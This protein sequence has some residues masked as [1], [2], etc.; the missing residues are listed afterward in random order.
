VNPCEPNRLLH[1]TQIDCRCQTSIV[2]EKERFQR[3][4]LDRV[5]D[6]FPSSPVMSDRLYYL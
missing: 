4:R 1:G 2:D 3:A 6:P 5:T